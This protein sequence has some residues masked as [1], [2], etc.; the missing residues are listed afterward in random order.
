MPSDNKIFAKLTKFTQAKNANSTSL[1][2]S[3]LPKRAEEFIDKQLALIYDDDETLAD[4]KLQVV[5][6]IV[7]VGF[8]T[9]CFFIKA[10]YTIAD[11]QSVSR[12]VLG[13]FSRDVQPCE[14]ERGDVRHR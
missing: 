3:F 12:R 8:S 14:Y 9:D 2:A 1:S 5:E 7:P 11:D 13:R 4:V 6:Q 10:L